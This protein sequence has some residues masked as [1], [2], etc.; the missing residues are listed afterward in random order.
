M[1]GTPAHLA[2]THRGTAL[3]AVVRGHVAVVD[4]D[5]VLLGC[6]GD[7]D[8]VTTLRSCIKPLQ[9]LPFVRF[10]ADT[11]R[12]SEAE[13]AVA[14]S[15]HSGEPVH[16]DAVQSLLGRCGLDDAALS[17]GPQEPFD[18]I[19]ARS[20]LAGGVTPGPIYNNCSGKHAGML[21]A[22]VARG[23]PVAGYA[24]FDHPLQVE[25]RSLLGGYAGTDMSAQPYGI[26]GCGLP[27]HQLPLRVLGRMFAAAA[28]DAGLRRCQDAMA[29]HPYLV[30]GR[31]RLDTAIL[32]VAGAGLTVKVGGAAVWVGLRRPRG[33]VL[34]IK[35]E[36][37][38]ATALPAVAL[39]ALGALGWLDRAQLA[40]PRLS[41]FV[42]PA[43]VNWAGTH[44]GATAV[45]PGWTAAMRV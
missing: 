5:G 30:A 43:L 44:V 37:G 3:E 15:S 19:A 16:V 34:A 24:H 35:L 1:P 29:A 39:A 40:D 11:L 7:P 6:A 18:H 36:A 38:D 33:P 42:A 13:I 26:D 28:V 10:A 32:S 22:C 23:W 31:D 41:G 25:I 4:A 20:L 9:A 45:E 8:A 14:C 12:A 21:A 27:T 17:C 2:T